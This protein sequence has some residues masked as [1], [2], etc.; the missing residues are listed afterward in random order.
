LVSQWGCGGAGVWERGGVGGGGGVGCGR[1]GG[2]ACGG[3][4]GVGVGVGGAGGGGAIGARNSSYSFDGSIQGAIRV[5]SS[6]S[7]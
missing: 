3:V 5:H 2:W 1:L 4:G 7:T 6:S